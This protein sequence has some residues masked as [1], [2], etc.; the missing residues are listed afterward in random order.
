MKNPFSNFLTLIIILTAFGCKT[1]PKAYFV[2]DKSAYN[3]G[4]TIHLTNTSSDATSFIWTMPDGSTLTTQNVDYY[5]DT[6]QAYGGRTF[7]LEAIS[8]DGKKRNSLSNTFPIMIVPSLPDSTIIF[9]LSTYTKGLDPDVFIR[10]Y[11]KGNNWILSFSKNDIF[12]AI[13]DNIALVILPGPNPPTSTTYYS[14]QSD[15]TNFS[16]N[17]ASVFMYTSHPDLGS[18]EA[19][20]KSLHGSLGIYVSNGFVRTVF[21]NIDAKQDTSSK[22]IQLSGN[23]GYKP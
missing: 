6:N 3:K 9:G 11:T 18:R 7:T 22:I 15:T 17:Q 20:Y 21:N 19:D 12:S 16:N 23:Y 5:I 1:E 4:E 8:K 13:S 2:A 10:F 14:L